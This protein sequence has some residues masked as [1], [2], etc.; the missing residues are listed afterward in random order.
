[1]LQAHQ[2]NLC[3]LVAGVVSLGPP[4]VR[5]HLT[6]HT[7]S[8]RAPRGECISFYPPARPTVIER[9]ADLLTGCGT[10]Q[11]VLPPDGA[12][13]VDWG[14]LALGAMCSRA[15]YTHTTPDRGTA[16]VLTAG[17][18]LDQGRPPARTRHQCRCEQH[19]LRAP[20]RRR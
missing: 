16:P 7:M 10:D 20:S 11:G 9:V 3:V 15:G 4:Q 17:R 13:S 12:L 18:L 2:S 8:A 19:H 5:R 1:M 6:R 14:E